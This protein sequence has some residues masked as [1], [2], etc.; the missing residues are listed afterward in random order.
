MGGLRIEDLPHYTYDDYKIWEGRWEL[1]DGIAYAMA[2]SPVLE[3]QNISA[4]IS[5]E[6]KNILKKCKQCKS[7]LALDWVITDDTIVCPDNAVVCSEIISS[8]IKTVPQI[9]FEVLSLSTKNTDR[10]RK[11]NLFQEHGVQYYILVDPKG[12]YAEIYK[13]ENQFY[14]IQ[15]E[16]RD[17]SFDFELDDCSI[18]FNFANIFE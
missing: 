5:Y 1:I 11:Y 8:F 12:N 9:I 13:L 16:Y 2:P 6:L 14:K 3:H 17:E 4:N 7:V 18:T 10:N 15:G